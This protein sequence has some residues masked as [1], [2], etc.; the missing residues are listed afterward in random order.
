MVALD[1]P[2]YRG[3]LD[4]E[5]VQFEPGSTWDQADRS[6]VPSVNLDDLIE[7]QPVRA[8]GAVLV[9]CTG[10]HSRLNDR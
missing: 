6:S 10:T 3:T 1:L 4:I 8:T 5:M 2:P 7:R 9:G